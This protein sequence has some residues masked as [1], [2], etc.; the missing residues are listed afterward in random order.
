MPL[1]AKLDVKRG[2]GRR[3]P[4][5]P[6][7]R[8]KIGLRYRCRLWLRRLRLW[9]RLLWRRLLGRIRRR[10]SFLRPSLL[11]PSLLLRSVLLRRPRL[12]R[13]RLRWCAVQ[14]LAQIIFSGD[15]ATNIWLRLPIYSITHL[16]PSD[17]NRPFAPLTIPPASSARLLCISLLSILS[18]PG[19]DWQTPWP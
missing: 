16:I 6:L 14:L 5:P 1:L 17:S 2:R 10:R 19:L 12:L 8:R 3:L 7:L 4:S 9:Q 11:R 13:T 15:V 18:C